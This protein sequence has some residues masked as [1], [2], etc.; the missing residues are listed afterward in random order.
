MFDLWKDELTEEETDQLIEKAATEIEKRKLEAPAILMLEAHKPLA[1]VGSQTSLM[2]APFIAP[3]LGFD[4]VNNYSRLFADR[5]NVE[6]LL[7]RIESGRA[8]E[9]K[10]EE[11]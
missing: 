7:R 4:F 3:F 9:P 10:V 5:E 8:T 1:F 11:S 6:R 2:F